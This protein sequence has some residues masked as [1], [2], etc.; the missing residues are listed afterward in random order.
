MS[1][2]VLML[3]LKLLLMLVVLLVHLQS[4][5]IVL[6]MLHLRHSQVT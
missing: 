6:E 3:M 1:I 2:W 5:E 4:I